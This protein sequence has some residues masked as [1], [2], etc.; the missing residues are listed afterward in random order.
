MPYFSSTRFLIGTQETS[1]ST[2]A[3]GLGEP[4]TRLGEIGMQPFE[5]NIRLESAVCSIYKF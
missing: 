1:G 4:T 3:R 2:R 5:Q